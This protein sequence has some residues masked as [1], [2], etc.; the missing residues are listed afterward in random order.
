MLDCVPTALLK[1]S[2]SSLLFLFLC[3]R[4]ALLTQRTHPKCAATSAERRAQSEPTMACLK[5]ETIVMRT[6]PSLLAFFRDFSYVGFFFSA[7]PAEICHHL[8]H[9]HLASEAFSH[10]KNKANQK[11]PMRGEDDGIHPASWSRKRLRHG[12]RCVSVFTGSTGLQLNHSSSYYYFD[13]CSFYGAES[14][15][16]WFSGSQ[17]T[18]QKV[19]R[20]QSQNI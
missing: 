14:I 18:L 11:I 2:L 19:A 3:C 4:P 7:F 12:C 15:S 17:N 10:L 8:C 5:K 13:L 20:Q 1:T 16:R 9:R 6:I